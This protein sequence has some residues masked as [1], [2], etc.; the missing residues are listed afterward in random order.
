M[1]R[2]TGTTPERGYGYDHQKLRNRWKPQVAT[3][4]VACHAMVCLEVRDGRSRLIAPGAPWHLGHTPDR[5]GW[6]GPEHERCGAADGARR[7]N[8]QQP[9]TIL[10]GHDVICAAC[11]K[12]Y[13]YAAR[14]CEV[15]GV[16]YHPSGKT[17]LTC[18]RTCGIEMR[19]RRYGGKMSSV[20]PGRRR[21]CDCTGQQHT[22]YTRI[23]YRNC[24]T[25]GAPFVVRAGRQ[26]AC[27]DECRTQHRT[28]MAAE[29][30][31]THQDEF[32]AAARRANDRKGEA[33]GW[34]RG[35]GAYNVGSEPW[36]SGQSSRQW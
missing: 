24:V 32:R 30:R 22:C 36:N 33:R 8:Q 4:Q 35:K 6:T 29:Y 18:S 1:A 14:S 20:K 28:A 34:P 9:R 5:T 10:A 21:S 16:H 11:G 7:G 26:L 17:V 19:R 12:P 27:S 2:W 3:G 23:S 31:R 15:C 13:H 25:C